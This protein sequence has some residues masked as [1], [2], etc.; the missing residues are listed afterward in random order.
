MKTPSFLALLWRGLL[1]LGVGSSAAQARIVTLTAND[2][3]RQVNLEIGDRLVVRLPARYGGGFA[4]RVMQN[5]PGMLSF[6]MGNTL[7][8]VSSGVPGA[9]ST[10]E[11][12]FTAIGAGGED[13]AFI[14]AVPG[15][16]LSPLGD[17]F[18]VYL[19]IDAPG[20]AAKNVDIAEGG[21]RGRVTVDQGDQ[22]TVKLGTTAGSGHRWVAVPT[23][24]NVVQLVEDKQ[25]AAGRDNA[26]L[27]TP[28]EEVFRFKALNP[29]EATV[30][31][32]YLD[33]SQETL[34][35]ARTFEMQVQVPK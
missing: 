31:F 3:G 10:S 28:A 19:T 20:G 30:R 29:G 13:L 32:L 27:G 35:P 16:G 8:G 2:N 7:P 15:G 5:S 24:G 21:N 26:A 22:V 34:P 25:Q 11:F 17:Y 14:S 9:G 18:H 4:W 12:R 23:P 1:W 33:P 6:V